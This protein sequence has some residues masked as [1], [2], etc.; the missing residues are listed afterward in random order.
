MVLVTVDLTVVVVGMTDTLAASGL[1]ALSNISTN[2]NG[3]T[4][5]KNAHIVR[6]SIPGGVRARV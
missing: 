2:N 3:F 6:Y 5:S 1:L 4:L